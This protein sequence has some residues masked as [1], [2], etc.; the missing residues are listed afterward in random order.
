M[1][2]ALFKDVQNI[3][4]VEKP[5][6]E[7][8]GDQVL[9]KVE[10]CGICGS[11]VH[12]YLN[13]VM[14]APGT[15]MGHECSG[16]IMKV[17]E[18]VKKYKPGDRVVAK[19]IPE[20][21]ECYWCHHGQYSL[22]SSAFGNAFGITP[23][24]DGAY[25]EYLLVEYPDQMLF[26]LPDSVTFQQGALVEPLST[27]LHAVRTSRFKP[28]DSVVVIGAGMIGLGTIQFLKIGGAG[29]IIVLEVSK[30]KAE[31]AKAVG[32]D[33][34]LDPTVEGEGLRPHIFELTG[35]TG[36]DIVYECSG[37][38]FG[39]QNGMF[40]AKS[41]G[42]VMIVGITDKETALNPFMLVLW[43][44]E[45]KGVLG[46]YDEFPYVIRYLEQ[47][48]INTE[49]F[50]SATVKLDELEEKGFKRLLATKDDVKILVHP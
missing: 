44:I 17:G 39:F 7:V 30:R 42:Q 6:P 24:H 25:A 11:D 1:K 34:V 13:G 22:C 33:Y 35:G 12:G 37:V 41:G 2:V 21:G 40:L 20:C 16:T 3:E 28:G 38:P 29:R 31:L 48:K 36:A 50:I 4:M 27:S 43:E 14:V 10:Y 46:Y 23:A 32:A 9:M 5:V 47:G 19:P 45:M 15:V 8:K 18:A 49:A 26:A